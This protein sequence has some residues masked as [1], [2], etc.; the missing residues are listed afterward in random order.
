MISF[1][2]AERA[3]RE[4]REQLNRA[5]QILEQ[6]NWLGK[7][8]ETIG[9]RALVVY[10]TEKT[11]D[12]SAVAP[13]L[14]D[15]LSIPTGDRYPPLNLTPQKRKEKTLHA[16]LAQVEGLAARRGISQA[17]SISTP[18]RFCLTRGQSVWCMPFFV[19]RFHRAFV[20]ENIGKFVA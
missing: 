2:S 6:G 20:S 17:C 8:G 12:L 16:Q 19:W 7:G 10:S 9:E 14:T 1:D 5:G 13:L 3:V 11:N 15:L 4:F 18:R